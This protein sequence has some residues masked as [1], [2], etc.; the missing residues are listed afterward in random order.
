MIEKKRK[1]E[2][3]LRR[4]TF[5]DDAEKQARAKAFEDSVN[6]ERQAR[7]DKIKAVGGKKRRQ[8]FDEL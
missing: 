8:N 7:L 5:L 3:E 1:E 4:I 6:A 2:D